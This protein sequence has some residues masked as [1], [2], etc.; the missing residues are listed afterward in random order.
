[1]ACPTI[2]EP[3]L[4][5]V[6]S[7]ALSPAPVFVQTSIFPQ[8]WMHQQTQE[9]RYPRLDVL[10]SQTLAIS[11]VLRPAESLPESFSAGVPL[12]RLLSSLPCSS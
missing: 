11:L 3:S 8:S 12:L 4:L 2:R 6:A 9:R 5:N 7:W 1:M 10:S